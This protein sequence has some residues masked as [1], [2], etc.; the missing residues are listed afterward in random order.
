MASRDASSLSTRWRPRFGRLRGSAGGGDPGWNESSTS[1]RLGTGP[2]R[3]LRFGR[4]RGGAGW[5][6]S[7]WLL[8]VPCRSGR[9]R[10]GHQGE[11]ASGGHRETRAV[12]GGSE[13]RTTEEE[14]RLPIGSREADQG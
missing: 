6:D 2:K 4:L 10:D 9:P 13:G 3:R 7:G 11:N 14:R 8:P 1:A 5:F 12:R